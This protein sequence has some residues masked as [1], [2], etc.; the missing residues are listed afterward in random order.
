[1]LIIGSA[2]K[3]KIVQKRSAMNWLTSKKVLLH[4]PKSKQS[5][6]KMK[7]ALIRGQKSIIIE[8]FDLQNFL[9]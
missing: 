7:L 1:M 4:R 6:Q 2:R 8:I 5:F 9:L 3:E